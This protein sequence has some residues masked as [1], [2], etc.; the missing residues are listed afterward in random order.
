[1]T[2]EE[3][4]FGLCWDANQLVKRTMRSIDLIIRQG[5]GDVEAYQRAYDLLEAATSPDST[6]LQQLRNNNEYEP[7]QTADFQV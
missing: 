5:V 1:M 4:Q 6:A 2:Q 7:S 3:S